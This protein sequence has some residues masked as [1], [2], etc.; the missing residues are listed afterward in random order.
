MTNPKV[1]ELMERLERATADTGLERRTDGQVVRVAYEG[2]A[3]ARTSDSLHLVMASGTLAIPSD[4]IVD[5]MP[6]SRTDP[7]V[8][9]VIVKDADAVQYVQG[10]KRLEAK[11]DVD[12]VM[13]MSMEPNQVLLRQGIIWEP[14][15]GTYTIL[16]GGRIAVLDDIIVIACW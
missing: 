16:A 6:L 13:A 14:I 8:V 9:R 4:Q 11:P 5:V 2:I 3:V 12:P 15:G 7:N 10:G 1:Q